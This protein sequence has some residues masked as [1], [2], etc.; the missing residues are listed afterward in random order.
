MPAVSRRKRLSIDCV[1]HGQ[2]R[3]KFKN[4][5]SEL[6]GAR[7]PALKPKPTC[8]HPTWIVQPNRTPCN[9]LSSLTS[10]FIHRISQDVDI[11]FQLTW[12]FGGFLAAIP[13]RLGTSAALD[14]ATDVLVAAH[15]GYCGGGITVDPSVLTK[16]SQALSVLRQDLNDVVKARSS[17]CLCAAL[18]LAIAQV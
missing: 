4:Q 1:G 6:V 17:E 3:Y 18:V 15:T 14:A 11:K 12:N 9:A 2:Q 8:N 7:R 16:Y 10:A 13:R 5:T